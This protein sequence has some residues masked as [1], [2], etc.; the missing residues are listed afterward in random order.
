MGCPPP[1]PKFIEGCDMQHYID[2]VLTPYADALELWLNADINCAE[3]I[4]R[5]DAMAVMY[6]G[7]CGAGS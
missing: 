3:F 2:F 5:V 4:A 6:E 7:A 1:I